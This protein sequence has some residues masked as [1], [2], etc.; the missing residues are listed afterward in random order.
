MTRDEYIPIF[1]ASLDFA[2]LERLEQRFKRDE[3]N[4]ITWDAVTKDELHKIMKEEFGAKHTDVAEVLSQFGQSRL[5]KS[6]DK[7]VQD[8][9]F[10]WSTSIPDIMK[11]TTDQERKD[12]V[13]L[14]H[15]SMYYISLEDTYLQKA[16]SD[17]KTPNPNLQAY[18]EE[19][20]AAESRRKCYQDI[21]TSSS[22]LDSKGV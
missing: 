11:P 16:L 2:V 1:R 8:F 19:T 14:I 5:V 4:L 6:P 13:D 20:V 21:N 18:Y 22:K 7:P 9:F 15:R 12:F 10:E 17:L 3:N